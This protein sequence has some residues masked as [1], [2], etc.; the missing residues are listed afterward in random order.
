MQPS[1]AG[2]V[3]NYGKAVQVPNFP[4]KQNLLR[5]GGLLS[6]AYN[7]FSAIKC[8]SLIVQVR[9][10]LKAGSRDRKQNETR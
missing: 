7:G 3:L 10:H 8:R 1:G 5:V 9:F 6:G 2:S 4:F